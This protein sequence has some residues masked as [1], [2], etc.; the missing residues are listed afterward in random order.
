[1]KDIVLNL[2]YELVDEIKSKEEYTRLLELKKVMDSDPY[3]IKLL[4]DF[5]N[6][7]KKFEEV[8][9]YGKFH[10]DLKKVQLEL[11]EIKTQVYTNK[12]IMEYKRLEK[13]LQ[14]ILDNTS[15]EIAESVSPTIKHPNDIG[16][17]NKH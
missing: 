15:R 16:L 11:S 17:I 14:K 10:P 3:I 13:E 5:K 4:D 9:K 6:S 2:V 1:M 12:T 8:S 7:K